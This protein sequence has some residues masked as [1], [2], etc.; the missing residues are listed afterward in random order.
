MK[1]LRKNNINAY[2]YA[3]DLA[4]FGISKS[5]LL[6]AINIVEEWARENKLTINKKKSGVMI[7]KFRGK[8]AK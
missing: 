2:A 6:K 3:D 7:H 1:R 5:N 4:M 8:A